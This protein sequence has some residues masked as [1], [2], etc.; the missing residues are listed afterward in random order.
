M[1]KRDRYFSQNSNQ[2]QNADFSLE[3]QIMRNS[4]K[5]YRF[6][7]DPEYNRVYQRYRTNLIRVQNSMPRRFRSRSALN[8]QAS[9]SRLLA[10]GFCSKLNKSG[11]EKKNTQNQ[12][13]DHQN[14]AC[15]PSCETAKSSKQT[16]CATTD[17]HSYRCNKSAS[18]KSPKITRCSSKPEPNKSPR[19]NGH[20]SQR[21][22]CVS[23]EEPAARDIPTVD[24]HFRDSS[25]SC[26]V[27]NESSLSSINVCYSQEPQRDIT[28]TCPAQTPKEP[29]PQRKKESSRNQTA[30]RFCMRPLIVVPAGGG[31]KQYQKD[32]SENSKVVGTDHSK[33]KSAHHHTNSSQKSTK[34]QAKSHR[35]D[36]SHSSKDSLAKR[37]QPTVEIEESI[38][39]SS[40]TYGAHEYCD[41]KVADPFCCYYLPEEPHCSK[42]PP[43]CSNCPAI[44]DLSNQLEEMNRRL[45]GLQS[46]DLCDIRSQVNSLNANLQCLAKE[47]IQKM[48]G[49]KRLNKKTS[50]TC[51]FCRGQC[52]QILD[53]FYRQLLDS[54]WD[55]CLTNIVI[56][57]FLRADNL[58][59]VNVRDLCTDCSLGCYLVTDAAIE[60]AIGLGVFENILTF[61]VIDVRNTIRSKNCALGIVFEYHHSK[62][63]TGGCDTPLRGSCMAGKEY[64]GRVLGLPLEQLKYLFSV[65]RSYTKISQHISESESGS[66]L[67]SVSTQT[68][69][70]D[71]QT[72][73]QEMKI[74]KKRS[75]RK[76]IHLS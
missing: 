17:E 74:G 43:P 65:P 35:L 27:S 76:K 5:I 12:S 18:D 55:R 42:N 59:H 51:Q 32:Q 46:Q 53:S 31:T 3:D 63:Q 56:S 49:V 69:V 67:H 45:E 11:K 26:T 29:A 52:L 66:Q 39:N 22:S 41:C 50:S 47:C 44:C 6:C 19:S 9:Q 25:C 33:S 61:S 24:L 54:L 70:T 2:P 28:K 30:T 4:Q 64:I 1:E 60:E 62:R 57:I 71:M 75:T 7:S 38:S 13:H 72:D 68:T 8:L 58:Y 15:K 23:F 40:C 10:G 37:G 14:D 73:I 34:K 20:E 21:H 16:N 48:D 36:K